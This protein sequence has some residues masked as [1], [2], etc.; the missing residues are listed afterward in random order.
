MTR[1]RHTFLLAIE[2]LRYSFTTRNF[3]ILPFLI[4]LLLGMALVGAIEA[5]APY[6]IYPIF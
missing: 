4:V 1:L 2:V 5:V 6:A 3:W